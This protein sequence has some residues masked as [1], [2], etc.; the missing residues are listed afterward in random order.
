M[1]LPYALS[2]AGLIAATL[3]ADQT[4]ALAA[5]DT[6][7]DDGAV[8]ARA[9]ELPKPGAPRTTARGDKVKLNWPDT[10]GLPIRGYRVTRTDQSTG[11]TVTAGGSCRGLVTKSSCTD[12]HVGVGLWS[13]EIVAVAGKSWTSPPGVSA[14]VL[15][16]AEKP[17]VDR[18]EPSATV[19]PTP[20]PAPT[21]ASAPSESPEPAPSVSPEPTPTSSASPEPAPAQSPSAQPDKSVEPDKTVKPEM[22]AGA[23][24]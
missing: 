3:I 12:R 24:A 8:V 22:S 11:R 20:T 23:T 14:P 1:R 7:A 6:P 13:Y 17:T 15:I 21:P 2:A 16:G 19:A 5:W 9:A 18:P 10:T 4:A